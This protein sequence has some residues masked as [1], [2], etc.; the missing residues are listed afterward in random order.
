MGLL[1]APSGAPVGVT[2][3]LRS[4]TT[5]DSPGIFVAAITSVRRLPSP[6]HLRQTLRRVFGVR[7]L[8]PGQDEVIRCVLLGRDTLAVMP[9]GYGKSLCYQLPGLFVAGTTLV[10]SPLISLMKDQTDKLEEKGIDAAQVN[11]A[12]TKSEVDE[13]LE[14][15]REGSDFVFT[16]PER[17][18]GGTAFVDMLQQKTI[19]RVVVDEAHCVS[20]WGHDF[21]PSFL[22]IKTTVE[23][24]GHPPMLALTA[25]ATPQVVDDIVSSLG[26]RSPAVVNTGIYR[27]NLRFEVVQTA[28]EHAKREHLAQLV[29]SRDGSGIIY[30]ATIKQVEAVYTDLSSASFSVA[31]YHGKV[32]R[33]E[34]RENQDRFMAGALDAIVA[35]N[36]FGMGHR[37]A[38]HPLR[39]PLRDAGIT[40]SLLSGSGPSRPRRRAGS[41]RV[42]LQRRGPPD[43]PLLHRG[44]I[45]RRENA[46]RAQRTRERC[47][48]RRTAGARRAPAARTGEAGAD[49]VVR[50]APD[51]PVALPA[52]VLSRARRT[53]VRV[54]SLRCVCRRAV[55]ADSP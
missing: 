52:R 30:A 48:R 51:L 50:A 9:T 36:A 33:A 21:R 40:R 8:R 34:R 5:A 31:R 54:R 24:L 44:A 11:S 16:T 46:S 12:L 45:S 41:L 49:G 6:Q 3:G 4:K 14:R 10:V 26:M 42:V 18:A 13:S 55:V 47:S 39:D 2:G 27:P 53:G 35:T 32:P 20:Q 28:S 19:A 15:V 38:R 25:T 29:Q 22:D 43:P 37:S 17:L 1:F 7:D 23:R